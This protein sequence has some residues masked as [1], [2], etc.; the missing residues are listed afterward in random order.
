MAKRY[1]PYS[2]RERGSGRIYS[3]HSTKSGARKALEKAE[4]RATKRLGPSGYTTLYIAEEVPPEERNP[5][6]MK[7]PKLGKWISAAKVRLVKR[8][9]VKVLEIRRTVKK[10]TT[11]TNKARKRKR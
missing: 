5:A 10:R 9:G 3:R 1:M 11:R 6:R 8:N 7:I 2:L 4:Q